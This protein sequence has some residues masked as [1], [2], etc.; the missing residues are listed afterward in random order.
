MTCPI[1]DGTGM[2][3]MQR[4]GTPVECRR[5]KGQGEIWSG[6]AYRRHQEAFT[7]LDKD[8]PR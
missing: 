3:M 7:M 4:D 2:T 1:C 5:C 8:D 6:E